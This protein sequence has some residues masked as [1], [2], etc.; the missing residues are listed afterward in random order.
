MEFRRE[1]VPELAMKI[2][3]IPAVRRLGDGC[4]NVAF[5]LHSSG[6]ISQSSTRKID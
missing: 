3:T 1:G 5:L 4:R 2:E 6:E